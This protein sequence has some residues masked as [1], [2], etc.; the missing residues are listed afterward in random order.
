MSSEVSECESMT[1]IGSLRAILCAT[2]GAFKAG[3][4]WGNFGKMCV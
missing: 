2:K 4:T 1:D 3:D